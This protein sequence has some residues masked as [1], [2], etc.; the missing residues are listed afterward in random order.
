MR[1]MEIRISYSPHRYQKKFHESGAR[2][3][4]MLAGIRGGKTIAGVMEGIMVSLGGWKTFGTPNVGCVV[5]PTYPMLRDVVLVEFFRFMP[6]EVIESFNRSEMTATLVNGS[7]ILFRSAD[8]PDRLRGLDLHWFH[9]DECAMAKKEAHDI[10]M[11]RISQK[12]GCGWYTTTPK[13]YNWVYE[14]LYKPWENGDKDIDVIQF[15]SIDN[16]YYPPEEIEKLKKKYTD[17]FYMQELEAKFVL[18]SG[19]VYKDFART[20]HVIDE[21]PYSKI[22]YYLAGVDWGYTNPAVILVIG[23]DGEDN[24]YVVREYYEEGKVID[25]IIE[26]GMRLKGKYG[27]EA[28]YCDPSEPAYIE[29]FKQNGLNA[30][31]GEN[32]IRAGINKVSELLRHRKLFVYSKCINLIREFESYSYPETKDEK[33]PDEIPLKLNDHALDALRYA[34]MSERMGGCLL[35]VL[36]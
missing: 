31:E 7:K 5:S 2:L 4:L 13:G 9:F 21:V 17:E 11:G 6:K 8:H 33:Q 22:K 12:R 25:E 29:Q 30:K 35:E 1:A 32:S 28:F 14:E 18:Y 19:L 24:F 3:R 23:V 27:I 10:L 36:E 20:V 15:R 26:A 16:P 34:C